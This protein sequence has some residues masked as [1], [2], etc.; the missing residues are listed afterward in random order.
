MTLRSGAAVLF[1]AVLLV[2]S[3]A[4]VGL[5]QRAP[6]ALQL[7]ATGLEPAG[8]TRA[9]SAGIRAVKILADW[10]VIEA[11]RG[12]PVWT[13]LDRAVA[14]AIQEGVIPVI[15]LAH[16]PQWAS[17]GTGAELQQQAIYSRQ[18]P[19]D[20]RDWE[21]FVSGTADRYRGR[22]REWQVWTQL[23]LPEFRGTGQEYV[24][25][26]QIARG[27]IRATDPG[28]RV[29]MA[30]PAG[31]DLTFIVR[32]LSGAA[33]TFDVVTL[34]PQGMTPEALLR[35]LA[36]LGARLRSAG[37]SIWIDWSPEKGIAADRIPGV[38]ARMQAVGHAGGVE[39]LFVSD[40][41]RVEG[42]IRQVNTAVGARTYAGYL[43][44]DSGVFV[45]VFGGASDAVALAWTRG[46][47]RTLELPAAAELRVSTL[48][49]QAQPPEVRENRAVIRVGE[50]PT[51]ISGLPAALVEEAR[52]N[53]SS[54]PLLP[55]PGPERDFSRSADVWA[56]LGR[57]GDERGLYNLPYR[58]RPNGAVEPVE[59]EGVEAVRTNISR[60]VVYLYFD[61]D[62]T[63][64][65]FTEGRA[66]IEI[67]VEMRGARAA[68]QLGFNILYDS[69]TGYRFSPW[70]W[71]EA[72]EGWTTQTIRLTDASFSNTWGWDFALNAAGNRTEDLTV[73]VVTVRKGAP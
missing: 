14:A 66:P 55:R 70:V 62:D 23:G 59:I 51:L 24:T 5:G 41:Q 16:T 13:D 18:P 48:E 22:V 60:Q 56:K 71:V 34:T 2:T 63:F 68:R 33:E 61:I 27:R 29:A 54:G 4:Q 64:M 49:G 52:A 9:K 12:Q 38:W 65:Y 8:F 47:G 19:R 31:I 69:A 25:L 39:R 73:R 11:R 10:S 1:T 35:P 46:E 20:L 45:A 57:V 30:T 32:V 36:V 3:G 43:L 53:V 28:A 50:I 17:L 42:G 7:G 15:V 44:K 40:L 67:V 26:L 58:A 37:K 21:R 72:G 6:A